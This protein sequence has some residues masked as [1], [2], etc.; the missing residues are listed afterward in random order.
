MWAVVN[1]DG[2]TGVGARCPGLEIA[3]KTGTAQV[4]S[5]GLQESQKNSEFNTNAWFVGYSPADKPEIVVSALVM[6]GG[7]SAVA[8]PIARDVIK[9]YFDK[10]LGPKPPANQ[11]ETAVRVLSRLEPPPLPEHFIPD[12]GR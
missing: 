10:K 2:G 7:H 1:E 12:A 5:T 6:H 11:M 4:V 3:G 8:V 9:A